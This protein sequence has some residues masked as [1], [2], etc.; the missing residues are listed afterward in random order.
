MGRSD[1]HRSDY[2]PSLGHM[3]FLE[4]DAHTACMWVMHRAVEGSGE[5]EMS[6]WRPFP[7]EER[8]TVQV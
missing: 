5:A 7:A 4:R 1:R 2:I 8:V 3:R 6:H